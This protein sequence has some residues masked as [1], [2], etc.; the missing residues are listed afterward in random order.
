MLGCTKLK[1]IKIVASYAF[2]EIEVMRCN[3]IF[4][5]EVSFQNKL[6]ST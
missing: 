4:I 2:Y 1:G 5:N 3:F 6:D